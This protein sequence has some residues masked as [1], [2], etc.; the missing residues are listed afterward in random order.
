MTKCQ[1]ITYS[2]AG[3]IRQ[4]NE[5]TEKKESRHESNKLIQQT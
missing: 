5:Y 2:R 4:S 1:Q 3:Y